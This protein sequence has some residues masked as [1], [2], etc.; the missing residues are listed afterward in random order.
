MQLPEGPWGGLCRW[1]QWRPLTTRGLQGTL[2]PGDWAGVR[3]PRS[4]LQ[5][6][7]APAFPQLLRL[8]YQL[9]VHSW[10]STVRLSRP[11]S[12]NRTTGSGGMAV[13]PRLPLILSCF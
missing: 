6:H 8:R 4:S 10:A 13:P 1:L 3:R 2:G 5:S 12:R 11:R 7:S 9:E